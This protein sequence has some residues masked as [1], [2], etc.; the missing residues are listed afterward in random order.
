MYTLLGA[1]CPVSHCDS[2][3]CKNLVPNPINDKGLILQRPAR[4][5][6][7]QADGDEDDAF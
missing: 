4:H 6:P 3:C 1:L 2:I 7:Q 5:A